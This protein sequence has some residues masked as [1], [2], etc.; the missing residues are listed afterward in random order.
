MDSSETIR[1]ISN[2]QLELLLECS[3][4]HRLKYIEKIPEPTNEHLLIGAAV[5]KGVEVY[6]IAQMQGEA[7]HWSEYERNLIVLRAMNEEFDKLLSDAENGT[8]R[9]ES[10]LTTTAGV[11]WSRGMNA[12]ISRKLC[13]ELLATYFYRAAES[14][15]PGMS[16]KPLALLEE[17]I[18]IEEDFFVPI[19][20][21]NNWHAKGRFDMRT[22]DALVDLKTAKAKYTQRDMDK[23]TQPSFYSMALLAKT[24]EYVGEFRY[25]ILVKPSKSTWSPG[26]GDPP[27]NRA[28][29]KAVVQRTQR[30]PAE[31]RWFLSLLRQQI[32]QIEAGVQVPR[33]NADWCDYCAV[34]HACKPWLAGGQGGVDVLDLL[35]EELRD[36]RETVHHG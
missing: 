25:H 30:Q 12:D 19:P 9:P 1:Y 14:D 10:M 7:V 28:A 31:I 20:G 36:S 26:D 4:K 35:R 21:T 17:P 2:S 13:K 11:K 34:A 22:K 3:W 5:H 16:G 27:T 18:S 6:R 15:I 24:G 8:T 23:K 29:Y 33:Q 32:L